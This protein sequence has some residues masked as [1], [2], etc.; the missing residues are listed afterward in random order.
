MKDCFILLCSLLLLSC[1]KSSRLSGDYTY[2]GNGTAKVEQHGEDVH[3]FLTWTPSG[4]G[5]H[6][7]V[8]GTL[9]GNII[10]GWWCSL[11][12]KT[13]W[14]HFRAEV[15]PS[16]TTIDFSKTEDPIGSQINKVKLS[17]NQSADKLP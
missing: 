12:A 5:P 14:Y 13:N 6:Y 17:I 10:D 3:M 7:E 9:S 16:G 2:L 15:S 1:A 8:K 11:N 4:A